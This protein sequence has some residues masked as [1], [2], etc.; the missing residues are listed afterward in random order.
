MGLDI[1]VLSVPRTVSTVR[2]GADIG[3]KYDAKPKWRQVCYDRNNWA[4]LAKLHALFLNNGG[5]GD[6]NNTNVRLYAKDAARL[7]DGQEAQEIINHIR[8]GRIVYARVDY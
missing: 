5:G 1:N 4:L 8:K 3:G 6:F 2:T 7:F